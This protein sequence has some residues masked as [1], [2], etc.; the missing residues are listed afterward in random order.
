MSNQDKQHDWPE[1]ENSELDPILAELGLLSP[2]AGFVDAVMAR[3]AVP[4][5]VIALRPVRSLSS[6]LGWALFGGYSVAS[7]AS[8]AL[9]IGMISQT[10]FQIGT[11][12]APAMDFALAMGEVISAFAATNAA[13]VVDAI[14]LLLG[15]MAALTITSLVSAVGL[16][17]IM[18]SYS[19]GRTSL[20][21][22]R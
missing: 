7:A 22:I 10:T 2:K 4:A 18:N 16:Y 5:H 6:K 8:L 1:A 14:P 19:T 9:L 13:A 21:A 11:L 12:S 3:V 20:N 15:G 17:R